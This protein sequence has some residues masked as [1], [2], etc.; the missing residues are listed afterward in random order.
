MSSASPIS[1]PEILMETH[2]PMPRMSNWMTSRRSALPSLDRYRHASP[3][4]KHSKEMSNGA[5]QSR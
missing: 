1:A 2:S 3:N 5:D 4:R